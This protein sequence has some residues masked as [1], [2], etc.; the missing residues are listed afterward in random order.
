MLAHPRWLRRSQYDDMWLC[1]LVVP[2]TL[3]GRRYAQ[4]GRLMVKVRDLFYAFPF[5][6]HRF[7]R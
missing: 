5:C 6:V 4:N 7:G 3:T 2:A 1:L